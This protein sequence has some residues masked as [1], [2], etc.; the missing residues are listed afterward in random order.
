MNPNNQHV[1]DNFGT[2]YGITYTGNVVTYMQRV[3]NANADNRA[4]NQTKNMM[5]RRAI[6]GGGKTTNG[7]NVNSFNM[8]FAFVGGYQFEIGKVKD[9]KG[10]SK[11]FISY[12]P[13]VGFA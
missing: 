10:A 3:R 1:P 11:W 7:G 9:S 13:T 6:S 8:G 5:E 2:N 4:F 12:G